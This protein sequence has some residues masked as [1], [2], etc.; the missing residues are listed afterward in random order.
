MTTING[1]RDLLRGYKGYFMGASSLGFA[2]LLFLGVLTPDDIDSVPTRTAE[3]LAGIKSIIDGLA[4]IA[5]RAG[6]KNSS[7]NGR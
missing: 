5:L 2:A 6:I 1:V 3:I 4:Q 7:T